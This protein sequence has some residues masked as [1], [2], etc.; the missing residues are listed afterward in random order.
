MET[1][2]SSARVSDPG[3]M[4]TYTTLPCHDSARRSSSEGTATSPD[5]PLLVGEANPYDTNPGYALLPFPVNSSGWRLC[6]KVLE[7]DYREYLRIFNRT[8]LCSRNWSV[9]TARERAEKIRG[10][11]D[12]PVIL[13]GA[14]V[15]LAF[16]I[17]YVP[18]AIQT[19]VLGRC[20]AIGV[21]PHPSGLCRVWNDPNSKMKAQALA[22][23]LRRGEE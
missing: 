1:K 22:L 7:M 17:P 2:N 21:L 15:C 18:F 3:T 4:P 5:K 8:N 14:K 16:G 13:L 20:R 11:Y 19:S 12:G 10:E 23:L 6:R 9:R